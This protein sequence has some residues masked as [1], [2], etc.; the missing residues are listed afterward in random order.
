MKDRRK[1]TE[2]VRDILGTGDTSAHDIENVIFSDY[3]KK[4]SLEDDALM[5][6]IKLRVDEN[7]KNKV[8]NL[9]KFRKRPPRHSVMK[10][11]WKRRQGRNQKR[12]L[13]TETPRNLGDWHGQKTDQKQKSRYI[14]RNIKINGKVLLLTCDHLHTYYLIYF[15]VQMLLQILTFQP[16]C[17]QFKM[18]SERKQKK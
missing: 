17:L 10:Q 12:K 16:M 18:L 11:Y 5:R 13:K 2:T 1:E 9:F 7:G 14:D 6:N 15:L 3:N 8:P 4:S